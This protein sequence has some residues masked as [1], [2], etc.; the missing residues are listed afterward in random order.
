MVKSPFTST[1]AST[2]PVN[3]KSRRVHIAP[4]LRPVLEAMPRRGPRVF[5]S[6]PSKHYPEG[7]CPLNDSSVLQRLKALCERC[8]FPQPQQYKVHTFRHTFASMCARSN[9]AH[10]YALGWMGHSSSR[11]LDLYYTQFDDVADEAMQTISYAN[12]C[13]PSPPGAAAAARATE[14]DMDDK[15]NMEKRTNEP[16]PSD[17]RSDS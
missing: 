5:Y 7:D 14:G 9:V 4:E 6:P 15:P 3:R 16:M 13:A 2:P 1:A 8:E 17:G 10:R 11:I 12:R